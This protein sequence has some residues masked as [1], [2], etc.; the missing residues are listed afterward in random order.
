MAAVFRRLAPSY[1][2]R[3]CAPHETGHH[4]SQ[5]GEREPSE[6]YCNPPLP[7]CGPR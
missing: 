3:P 2:P 7:M 1:M 5:L 4:M 6:G